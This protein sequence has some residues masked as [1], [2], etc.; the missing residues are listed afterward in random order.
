M[1]YVLDASALLAVILKE[2]GVVVA[3]ERLPHASI[4]TVN[5]AEA[6][7]RCVDKGVAPAL[8]ETLIR[9]EQVTVVDF[10]LALAR[11][12]AELRPMTKARGLSLGDRACIATATRAN[13][14]VVTADRAWK[15]LDLPC[16]VELIR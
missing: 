11:A 2:P 13:A 3:R 12:A 4:S 10:D 9:T 6:L 7:S 16:P 1:N 15:T 8:A 14:T 5:V